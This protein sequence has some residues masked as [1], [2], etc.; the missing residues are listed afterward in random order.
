MSRTSRW[1]FTPA[2]STP[3]FSW[4][5]WLVFSLRRAS[6]ALAA[7]SRRLRSAPHPEAAHEPVFEFH[8]E[9]GAPEGALFVDGQR[10]GTLPGVTRL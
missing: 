7:L 9:A 2:L 4:R 3:V 8:A 10:V 1:A 6:L 5:S